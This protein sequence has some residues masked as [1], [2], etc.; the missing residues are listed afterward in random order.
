MKL[1]GVKTYR[2]LAFSFILSSLV[3]DL[4]SQVNPGARFHEMR[5]SY[6]KDTLIQ[7]Q[8]T[9]VP[10]TVTLKSYFT[11]KTLPFSLSDNTIL[12]NFPQARDSVRL[13]F[14][15]IAYNLA[16]S[17]SV[18]DSTD[19]LTEDRV[20]RIENN[21]GANGQYNRRIIENQKLEYSGS[22]SRGIS[23]GNTQDVV[24]NSNFNLQMNGDLG[25]G[26]LV[27]AAISD[28]NI[29]IQPEGNTQVLQEFDK[30]F[31][32]IQKDKTTLVAGDYELGRPDSYFMNYYKKLKGLS[33]QNSS[34]SGNWNIENKAGFAVSRGKFRRMTLPIVEGNQGPYKL[35]GD[36]GEVF[37]QVL[38]GTE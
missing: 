28:D 19:I 32:E 12:L 25:N 5:F 33:V 14:R 27:K 15:T 29:P 2:I 13:Q 24:L 22:F 35:Q 17:E 7:T 18:L 26:L 34:R 6:E 9:I 37:L 10:S 4:N 30:I 38:S 21:I 23:F 20:I 8:N 16:E 11:G 36:N 1:S 31:I 3:P